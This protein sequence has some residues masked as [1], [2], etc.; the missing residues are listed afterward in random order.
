[1]YVISSKRSLAVYGLAAFNSS[2]F[3][4]AYAGGAFHFRQARA[5]VPG[6]LPTGN[7]R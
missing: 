5:A 7:Y 6:G 2:D 4:M 1:M 3:P